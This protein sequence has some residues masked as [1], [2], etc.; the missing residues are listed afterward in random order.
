MRFFVRRR[1]ARPVEVTDFPFVVLETDNWD[2][3]HFGT[4]FHPVIY[5]SATDSVDLR[6]VKILQAGQ[7]GHSP[8]GDGFAFDALD[9]SYCSLGQELAYYESL[10]ALP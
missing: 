3:F 4:L 2:D 5:L 7:E 10:M 1:Q 6:S 8:I 9:D